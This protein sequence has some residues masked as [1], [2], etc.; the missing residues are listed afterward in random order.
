MVRW[1]DYSVFI[2]FGL[3]I[4]TFL[5]TYRHRIETKKLPDRRR[6]EAFEDR[7]DAVVCS[8]YKHRVRRKGDQI[9]RG[10]LKCVWLSSVRWIRYRRR[11]GSLEIKKSNTYKRTVFYQYKDGKKRRRHIETWSSDQADSPG[12]F[13]YFSPIISILNHNYWNIITTKTNLLT[14]IRTIFHRYKD[15]EENWKHSKHN[16]Y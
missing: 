1:A 13:Q 14:Y 16:S 11:C 3:Y 7:S 5:M 6:W 4:V 8:S 12:Q 9:V 10:C 2:F 15:D